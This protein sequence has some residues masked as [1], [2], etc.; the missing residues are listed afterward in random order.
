MALCRLILVLLHLTMVATAQAAQQTLA[1]LP[2]K[3]SQPYLATL[4]STGLRFRENAVTTALVRKPIAS[5]PPV[6]AITPEATE[7]ALANNHAAASTPPF[8]TTETGPANPAREAPRSPTAP[9]TKA[10]PILP[11]DTPHPAQ[12]QDFLPLFRFPGRDNS[13]PDVVVM[14]GLHSVLTPPASPQT[15]STATYHQE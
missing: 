4:G 9:D 5:G 10:Q 15:P 12:S 1:A 14:P 6:A 2:Q 11:D 3:I 8:P 7:V 13:N